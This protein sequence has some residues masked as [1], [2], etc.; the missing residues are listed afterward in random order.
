MVAT[1][2]LC[3]LQSLSAMAFI[4]FQIIY[5]DIIIILCQ[6]ERQAGPDASHEFRA[7][8]VLNGLP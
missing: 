8:Q 7:Q 2:F 4:F 5:K 3:H 6:V 1:P